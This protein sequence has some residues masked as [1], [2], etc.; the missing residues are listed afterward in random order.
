M[1][2]PVKLCAGIGLLVSIAAVTAGVLLVTALD[3]QSLKNPLAAFITRATGLHAQ[4]QGTMTI[5]LLPHAGLRL[6]NGRL[7]NPDLPGNPEVLRVASMALRLDIPSLL[8]GRVAVTEVQAHGVHLTLTR[9]SLGTCT[10]KP[11]T[12]DRATPGSHPP[13][14]DVPRDSREENLSQRFTFSHLRTVNISQSTLTCEDGAGQQSFL[15]DH[16]TVDLSIQHPDTPREAALHVTGRYRQ[17]GHDATAKVNLNSTCILSP[18]GEKILFKDFRARLKLREKSLPTGRA[19]ALV[20]GT[21]ALNPGQKK[22]VFQA[23][24]A[25]ALDTDLFTSSTL[26]LAPLTWEGGLI[27]NTD[28]K[29][30]LKA[31]G[32]GAL[33]GST[34]RIFRQ[35]DLRTQFKASPTE[36]RLLRFHGLLDGQTLSGEG[37]FSHVSQPILTFKIETDRINITPYISKNSEKKPAPSQKNALP[38]FLK[39]LHVRGTLTANALTWKNHTA[40]GVSTTLRARKGIFRIYPLKAR[41]REGRVHANIRMDL[42]P[43]LPNIS[44][45]TNIEGISLGTQPDK[46]TGRTSVMGTCTSFVDITCKGT[47]LTPDLSTLQGTASVQITNGTLT[48]VDLF[49]EEPEP[50]GTQPPGLPSP[51]V[52][53]FATLSFTGVLHGGI[54]STQDLFLQ[55]GIRQLHGTGTYD[56]ATD[57]MEGDMVIS[58]PPS[59]PKT[60]NITGSVHRPSLLAPGAPKPSVPGG[61]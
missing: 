11:D 10:W 48:G 57:Q 29:K 50:A 38:P 3:P 37:R 24:K 28:P 25:H 26:N 44:L 15:L 54:L 12:A 42:N 59:S 58:D 47:P 5:S 49:P 13:E 1:R 32:R 52:L 7:T 2:I 9:D 18:D 21:L 34:P 51:R 39:T 33:L 55:A 20:S 40:T 31:M 35:L 61:I 56:P 53:P 43:P 17:A 36:I 6:N 16:V 19:N 4:I 14:K 8:T 23:V 27:F 46:E 22:I 60:V 45:K 41:F 30:F